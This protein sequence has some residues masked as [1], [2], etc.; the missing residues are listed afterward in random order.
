MIF[1]ATGSCAQQNSWEIEVGI[2]Y[3]EICTPKVYFQTL[4]KKQQ[5]SVNGWKKTLIAYD[6]ERKTTARS[7]SPN[8]IYLQRRPE[9]LCSQVA[10]L[11]FNLK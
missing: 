7:P 3:F 10:L 2:P 1:I 8:R 9:R 5:E 6:K 4:K 11:K